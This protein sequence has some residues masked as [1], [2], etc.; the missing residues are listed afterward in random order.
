M[1]QGVMDGRS[2][3]RSNERTNRQTRNLATK[4]SLL[5]DGERGKGEPVLVRCLWIVI[6]AVS[7][8]DGGNRLRFTLLVGSATGHLVKF[9]PRQRA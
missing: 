5:T 1:T 4:N 8:E 6:E 7:D 9:V 2:N 3:G